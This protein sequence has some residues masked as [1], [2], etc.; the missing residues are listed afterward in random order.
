MGQKVTHN[1][2]LF[3]PIIN[4]K[5]VR[6]IYSFNILFL[7]LTKVPFLFHFL[8]LSLLLLDLLHSSP[9]FNYPEYLE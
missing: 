5:Y 6:F 9:S 7:I 1:L 2:A 8:V 3:S 4:K